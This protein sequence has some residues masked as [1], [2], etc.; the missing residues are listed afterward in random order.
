MVGLGEGGLLTVVGSLE[1]GRWDVAA[2]FEK[3][4]VVE[5]VDVLEG[6]DFDLLDGAPRAARFDSSVLNSPITLSASALS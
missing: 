2:G 3:T 5:P 1:F 4:P 6:G